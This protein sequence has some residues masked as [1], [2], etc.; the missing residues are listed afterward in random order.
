VQK[1]TLTR[2]YLVEKVERLRQECGEWT[3]DIPL[4]H[5]VWTRGN[6]G[7]PA[8][9]LRRIV[10]SVSDLWGK[11]FDGMRVLDLA[12]LEG[13]FALE[14][15][16][17]S[18]ECIGVEVREQSVRKANFLK[19]ALSLDNVKFVQDDV[20]NVSVEKYGQFDIVLCNG[21]LYHL[22]SR[23][24]LGLLERMYQL[25]RRMVVID[26]HICLRQPE[27]VELLGRKYWGCYYREHEDAA[28]EDQKSAK[29]W[30]SWDNE[31]SFWFTRPSLVNLLLDVGFSSVHECLSPPYPESQ[32]LP[33]RCVFL[34][35]KTE[36]TKL[37]TSPTANTAM[38]RWP[39]EALSY[40]VQRFD[41]NEVVR[42][43]RQYGKQP[44]RWLQRLTSLRS[45]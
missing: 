35:M 29:A 31:T 34:A 32:S 9:R 12:C 30:A 5:G 1:N 41:A 18:A 13:I 11:P 16:S 14:F 8:M 25:T 45:K 10:Q 3:Y 4:P 23:D 21:I 44:V 39:E 6:E 28:T 22:T 24:A 33:D 42:R 7:V 19:E 43:V 36:Q 26:T 37:V 17:H 2:E 20:R 27:P 40:A 38:L 15:A